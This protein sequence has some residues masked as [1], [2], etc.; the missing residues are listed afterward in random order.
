MTPY[1]AIGLMSGTSL[2]G[3]DA[4][5]IETDGDRNVRSLGALSEAYDPDFRSKLRRALAGEIDAATLEAEL[6]D[7]HAA[8][9]ERLLAKF[10][11]KPNDVAVVGFH[12]QT[13][14]HDPQARRTWQIGDGQ[15]LADRLGVDVV[16]DFR[17]A[18]VAAG[19]EG[20]PLAPIYHAALAAR[21][22]AWPVAIVN[23]GGVA[24]VT[25]IGEGG[26]I[27]ACDVGPGNGPIDDWMQ[28]LA[29]KPFDADGA[30]ARSGTVDQERI[31]QAL[32]DPFFQRPAPKSLDRL[33]FTMTLAEGLTLANGAATLTEFTAAAIARSA[34]TLPSQPERWL[35]VGGGRHNAYLM[36]RLASLVD[37]AVEPIEAIGS[38]GDFIEA[39]AFAYMAV[40]T[41]RGLPISFPET[42][43]APEPMCGGRLAAPKALSA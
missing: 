43:G 13:I 14:A 38:D 24:N 27:V 20:A 33:D 3:I 32:A 37:G 39:E 21:L 2:D 18:D 6:T 10:G 41:K 31:K 25:W 19:G 11:R 9:V 16:F 1:L 34:E 15:R 26:R 4:A 28:A 12:G 8:I 36:E 22:D 7:R 5:L 17:S 29:G 40:R 35:V 42:T 30:T 23:I